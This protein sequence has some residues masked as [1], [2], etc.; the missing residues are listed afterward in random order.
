MLYEKKVSSFPKLISE[1]GILDL[2]AGMRIVGKYDSRKCFVFVTRSPKGYTTA[3][4][5][6]KTLGNEKLPDKRLTIKEFDT[7]PE[8]EKFLSEVIIKPVRAFAY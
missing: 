8:L 7:I 3:L 1:I 5:G 4:Y 2:D 6:I